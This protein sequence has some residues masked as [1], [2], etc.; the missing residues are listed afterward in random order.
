MSE[1]E[2]AVDVIHY[3]RETLQK[4]TGDCD[5]MSVLMCSL[6]GNVGVPTK[7]VDAPGHLMILAGTGIHRNQAR[8][9]AV[10][11]YLYTIVDEEIWIP[12]ETTALGKGFSE[13]W[14][15]GAQ[16]Y[17]DW[18]ARGRIF[19]VDVALAQQRY[20]P[21][22]PAGKEQI[23]PLDTAALAEQIGRDATV[24]AGWRQEYLDTRFQDVQHPTAVNS[25]GLNELAYVY[26]IAKKYK[27]AQ[28]KL[29]E[30][31]G[32]DAGSAQ[33]NN[34]L[35]AV[36]LRQGRGDLALESLLA[37]EAGDGTDPG[38][39]LNLGLAY[40]MVGETEKGRANLPDTVDAGEMEGL[41]G[42]DP[43]KLPTYWMR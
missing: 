41:V 42:S 39:Q 1:T 21:T 23:P 40:L 33:T 27:E 35:A 9:L 15:L 29:E 8:G 28:T 19:L 24:I 6:L 11:E 25:S 16:G 22:L 30:A 37:A 7:L 34:N 2:H 43:G 32:L 12:I 14:R 20:E 5:D 4:R 10:D 3:P 26:Y 18:D 13:A 38:I 31:L 36:Y 17:Q